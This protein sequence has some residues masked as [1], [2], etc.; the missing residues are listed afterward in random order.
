MNR[1]QLAIVVSAILMVTIPS[2]SCAGFGVDESTA[3]TQ[4]TQPATEQPITHPTVL[5][6]APTTPNPGTPLESGWEGHFEVSPHHS[7]QNL[8]I[9]PVWVI[10]TGDS[11]KS[12]LDI[13]CKQAKWEIFW[14]LPSSE[15]FSVQASAAFPGTF[16]EA[17]KRLFASFPE[18]TDLNAEMTANHLL[19]ITKGNK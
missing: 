6:P 5:E 12:T 17:V 1:S 13:W 16:E 9:A 11:L 15:D 18:G 14:N 19:Y 4:L 3:T 8:D 7:T 10:H 2:V